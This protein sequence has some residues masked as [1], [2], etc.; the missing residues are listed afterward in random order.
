MKNKFF[1]ISLIIILLPLKLYGFNLFDDFNI[2]YL[3][4]ESEYF[5]KNHSDIDSY[6]TSDFQSFRLIYKNIGIGKNIIKL[7][8]HEFSKFENLSYKTNYKAIASVETN[9]LLLYLPFDAF[10]LTLAKNILVK[11]QGSDNYGKLHFERAE[12]WGGINSSY[13][14]SYKISFISISIG[15]I[16]NDFIF[17]QKCEN[18]LCTE[19]Y[20]HNNT[21][22]LLYGLSL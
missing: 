14:F 1:L 20:F 22:I 16:Q 11:G 4:G 19:E 9:D 2:Q 8:N 17:S 21:Y 18:E 5:S 7:E 12:E 10:S 6:S 13:I 15:Y 3:K